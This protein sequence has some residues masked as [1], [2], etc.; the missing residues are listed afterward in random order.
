[1]FSNQKRSDVS[2]LA[3]GL[4]TSDIIHV[5]FL[6]LRVKKGYVATIERSWGFEPPKEAA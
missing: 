4:G 6:A 3:S 1:M 2:V 5:D